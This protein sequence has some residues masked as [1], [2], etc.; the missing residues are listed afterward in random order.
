LNFHYVYILQSE[1]NEE[2]FHIGMMDDL[3]AQ[4]ILKNIFGGDCAVHMVL[5]RLKNQVDSLLYDV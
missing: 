3:K 4:L 1:R 5:A 2:H